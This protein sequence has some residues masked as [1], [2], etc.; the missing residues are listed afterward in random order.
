MSTPPLTS[1]SDAGISRLVVDDGQ[2]LLQVTREH[3]ISEAWLLAHAPDLHAAWHA[4][5]T[6]TERDELAGRIEA[7]FD[8]REPTDR[9]QPPPNAS[10]PQAGNP[11]RARGS[12]LTGIRHCDR[13]GPRR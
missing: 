4:A 6:P 1:A 3:A 9:P 5:A 10:Y 13:E 7:R 12:T 8:A 11:R 2:R